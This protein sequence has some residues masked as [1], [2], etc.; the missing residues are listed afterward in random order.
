VSETDDGKHRLVADST[1]VARSDTVL[2]IMPTVRR[3]Q[4]CRVSRSCHRRV[5]KKAIFLDVQVPLMIDDL[6]SILKT[7][8][9]TWK[10]FARDEAKKA[11]DTFMETLAESQ[12]EID[13]GGDAATKPKH[14]RSQEKNG[15]HQHVLKLYEGN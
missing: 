11:R 10:K 15:G 9:L 5:Q 1:S 14:I 12:D 7:S 2:E 4:G 6:I 13:G 3:A 8:V